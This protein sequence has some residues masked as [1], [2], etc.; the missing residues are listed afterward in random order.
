MTIT[1]PAS[2]V[3]TDLHIITHSGW[4]SAPAAGDLMVIFNRYNST[5][6]VA[7]Q[8]G[9]AKA[10]DISN[11]TPRRLTIYYKKATGSESGTESY[12]DTN[13]TGGGAILLRSSTA[14]GGDWFVDATGSDT[15]VQ[16]GVTTHGIGTA[17]A[18]VQSAES[19]LVGL[20]ALLNGRAVT[21]S[22]GGATWTTDAGTV[23]APYGH[24]LGPT[25]GGTPTVSVSWSTSTNYQLGGFATIRYA[26]PNGNMF[27]VF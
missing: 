21:F 11:A 6:A 3:S 2:N 27:L 14:A 7:E 25:N 9:W 5:S 10:L 13:S 1:S 8:N 15:T 20:L 16:S 26:P 19:A 24:G 23:A 4:T 18:A 12:C 22:G 17:S